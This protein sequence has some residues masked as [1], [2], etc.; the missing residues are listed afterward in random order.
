MARLQMRSALTEPM[1]IR[2]RAEP[3]PSTVPGSL[4][5]LSFGDLDSAAVA[6]IG[7]N[8]SRQEYLDRHGRE[9]DGSRR[10]FETLAS[11]GAPHR[12]AMTDDQ[13][14]RAVD[15]MRGYFDPGRP[16]YSWFRGLARVVDGMG[17]CFQRRTAAHLDLVQEATDPVWSGLGTAD[18]AQ[19]RAVLERDLPFLRWQI[20]TFPFHAV[21]CTSTRVLA[22]V[23]RLLQVD[24]VSEGKLARVTWRVGMAT[25][26][27]GR[28]GV[29][30]WNIPLARPTGLDTEGQRHLGATLRSELARAGC[31][32]G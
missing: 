3:I 15:R 13:M 7:L 25:L 21:V 18:P 22:E 16:I 12:A 2:L 29:V 9:L 24:P 31:G 27:R 1:I 23:T 11:L 28:V 10:R 5:V 32:W 26:G 17:M 4:P 19:A 30:G 8:P 20:E 14:G 6:T